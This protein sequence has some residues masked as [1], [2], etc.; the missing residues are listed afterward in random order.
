M[1]LQEW[2]DSYGRGTTVFAVR[3]APLSCSVGLSHKIRR[4]TFCVKDEDIWI[5]VS[6]HQTSKSVTFI[7]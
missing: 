5:Y 1:T 4:L 2:A 7:K 3:P 6:A